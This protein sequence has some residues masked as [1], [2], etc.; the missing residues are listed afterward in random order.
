MSEAVETEKKEDVVPE[1]ED[2]KVV[3]RTIKLASPEMGIA[4]VQM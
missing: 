3:V 1:F 2:L 4:K